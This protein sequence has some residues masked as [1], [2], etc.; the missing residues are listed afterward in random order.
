MGIYIP[1]FNL[2]DVV[3]GGDF[4]S[5]TRNIIGGAVLTMA[6]GDVYSNSILIYR[7]TPST[8]SLRLLLAFIVL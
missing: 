1:V 7:Y 2:I 6:K 3:G 4:A 5:T 8:V